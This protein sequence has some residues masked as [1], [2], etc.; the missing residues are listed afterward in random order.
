MPNILETDTV[1]SSFPKKSSEAGIID[2]FAIGWLLLVKAL[3]LRSRG[4]AYFYQKRKFS[5]GF[6]F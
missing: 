6:K 2:S 3:P 4:F 5:K 1:F